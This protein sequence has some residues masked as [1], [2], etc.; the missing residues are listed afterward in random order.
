MRLIIAIFF[1]TSFSW[2]QKSYYK[3]YFENGNMKS[4][5]WQENGIKV[6]YWKF[7]FENSELSSEGNYK[8]GK[9]DGH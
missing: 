5:G 7:Y 3:A 4:E 6:D 1:I 2:A 9:K 8:S